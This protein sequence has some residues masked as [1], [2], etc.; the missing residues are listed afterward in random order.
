MLGMSFAHLLTLTV[1]WYG[2]NQCRTRDYVLL[3][4]T[5]VNEVRCAT[6]LQVVTT[7][8]SCSW[9][10][11]LR[12]LQRSTNSMVRARGKTKQGCGSVVEEGTSGVELDA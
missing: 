1:Q 4:P 3:V 11:H 6:N 2:H 8:L 9:E 10:R 5:S 12:S 7:A